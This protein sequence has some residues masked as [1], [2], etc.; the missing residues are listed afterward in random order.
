M[1]VEIQEFGDFVEGQVVCFYCQ[2]EV[3]VGIW[4]VFQVVVEVFVECQFE[5]WG[6]VEQCFVGGCL[7]GVEFFVVEQYYVVEG[8][9]DIFQ[10]VV[11]G[12]IGVVVVGIVLEDFEG[13]QQVYQL[14]DVFGIG[15]DCGGQC[16]VVVDF[17]FDQ[18]GQ[19]EVCSDVDVMGF[20]FF[21]NN[22]Y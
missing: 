20:L 13:Y 21:G 9:F 19:F 7:G 1:F 8:V 14:M 15:I 18:I 17:V 4:V 12:G 3:L 6:I 5:V 11:G 2:Q 10:Q 22:L 16:F